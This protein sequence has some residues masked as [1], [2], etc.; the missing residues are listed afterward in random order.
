MNAVC[1]SIP[2]RQKAAVVYVHDYRPAE[3]R[4]A[5]SIESGGSAEE[6]PSR[7]GDWAV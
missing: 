4:M 7:Y 2:T 5:G 1:R 3:G 6:N